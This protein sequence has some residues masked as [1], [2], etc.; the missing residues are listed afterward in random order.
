MSYFLLLLV[1][2]LAAIFFIGTVF[3]EVLMLSPLARQ[4]S[5]PSMREFEYALGRRARRIMPWVLLTLVSSGLGLLHTHYRALLSFP[6]SSFAVL[7]VCKLAL[8]VSVLVQ[9]GLI[10]FWRSRHV[11][12]ARRSQLIHRSVW[13]HVLLIALFVSVTVPIT[14]GY[15]TAGALHLAFQ[16]PEVR[17]GH[18]AADRP[19]RQIS[20]DFFFRHAAHGD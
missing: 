16:R 11:L 4:V 19:D 6:D 13:V 9:F 17:G 7:L 1:H 12:T 15:L 2:L 14:D 8:V 3:F 20:L 18:L 10:K 5:R